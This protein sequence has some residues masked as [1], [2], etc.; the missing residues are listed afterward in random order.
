MSEVLPEGAPQGADVA[1]VEPAP[2]EAPA[3]APVADVVDEVESA[4]G[5]ALRKFVPSVAH[6]ERVKVG[7]EELT[8]E[9]LDFIE[10]RGSQQDLKVLVGAVRNLLNSQGAQAPESEV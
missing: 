9:V 5:P 6:L 7:L 4:A 3:E 8:H 1:P 10:Q 2:V